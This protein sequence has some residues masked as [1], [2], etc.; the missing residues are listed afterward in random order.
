MTPLRYR[1]TLLAVA[2]AAAMTPGF[3]SA[4]DGTP[5]PP[6]SDRSATQLDA[7][8]VTAQRREESLQETPVTITALSAEELERQQVMRIDDLK[9][10]V[11]NAVI[12][13]NTVTS[14][15][16]RV[17]LR[18]VGTD[19][20]LFTTDPAV[21]IYIDDIYIPRQTGAMFDLYDVE[22]IEV[23]RGPQG[24]LYGRNATGGAIRYITKKPNG[25]SSGVVSGQIGNLGRADLRVSLSERLGEW[26]DFSAAALTRNR[27]GIMRDVTNHRDVN[28]Q[29]IYAARMSFG[30]PLGELTRATFTADHVK[31]RSGPVYGTGVIR[32]PFVTST[33]A[34][35]PVNDPD[36]N[37]YTLETDLIPGKNDIDQT[38]ISLTLETDLDT[39]FW[40]N[41]LHYR[42]L[43]NL[44][45]ADAD[46]TAQKRFHLLQDQSQNQRGFETQLVSQGTGPF[47]WTGGIF[48]FF[49]GNEQPTRQDNFVTGPTNLV[50]QDTKAFAGYL[51]GSWRFDNKFGLTV[52]GRYSHESKRFTIDSVLPNGLPNFDVKRKQSWSKPDWKVLL[53]YRFTDDIMG[54]ASAATGF[55]SGGFNGRAAS[56]AGLTSVDEETVLSYEVG[57]KTQLLDNRVRLNVNYFRNDY[58]DLQL[59]AFNDVGALVLSN[60]TDTLIQGFEGELQAII[61]KNWQ[62]H[63]SVGTIDGEYRGFSEANRPAFEGKN[64]KQAPKLQY[65]VGTTNTIPLNTGKLVFTAQAHY[66]DKYELVQANSPLVYAKPYTLVDA[67]L[68]YEP[69]SEKWMVALWSKNLTDAEYM[70]GGFDIAGLGMATAYMNVPRTYGVDFR[71]RFW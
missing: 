17:Y 67:R 30:F 51:Q 21:A 1:T 10:S 25:E 57:L 9:F 62:V 61:T 66:S 63:S 41:I 33:G 64:L 5:V 48:A 50:T 65:T 29:E 70:T 55:K 8:T 6:A 58:T 36:R 43:D 35:R 26:V 27:D 71:Y 14:S 49:E 52:G 4:Q 47:T 46:A 32:D 20:S 69:D 40:R 3:A 7:V 34:I 39:V 38:G 22:R 37:Y 44:L 28:D 53:D 45:Y 56:V 31:E 19:D 59:Q 16:A 12:G 2:V 23:L 42:S 60:A 24:T 13:P 15:A 18:G 54:Y 68:A 11:P